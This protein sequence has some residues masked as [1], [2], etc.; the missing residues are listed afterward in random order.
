MSGG[1]NLWL[2]VL[3]AVV[4]LPPLV[5][6]ILHPSAIWLTAV[7]VMASAIAQ[8]EFYSIT[9]SNEPNWVRM[10]GIGLGLAVLGVVLGGA[11]STL[12]LLALAATV[13]AATLLQLFVHTDVERATSNS[14]LLV[15]GV[16]YVPLLL[17]TVVLLKTLPRGGMWIFALLSLTWFSDTG[18]YF[19]GRAFGKRPLYPRISPKKSQEG[20][21]GGLLGATAAITIAKLWYLPELRWHDVFLIALPAGILGQLG[22][23]V[24]SMFKR[25]FGV[26]DSGRILPGHGGLLDRIDALLFTAPYVYFYAVLVLNAQAGN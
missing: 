8:A 23:L 6:A 5:V 19:V 10:A 24:E 15:L 14:A 16:F 20:G 11:S 4:L 22:D 7:V 26:K 13:L 12:L 2:R 1:R 21:L 3:S 17:S 25:S 9:L 18:A